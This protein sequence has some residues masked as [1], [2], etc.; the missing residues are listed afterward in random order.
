MKPIVLNQSSLKEYLSCN[1]LYGWR[2]I[3]GLDV[4]VRPAAPSIGIAVHAGLAM[5]H[6]L[7]GA[8]EQAEVKARVTTKE[9]LKKQAGPT[10]AFEDKTLPEAMAIAEGL[11]AAYIDHWRGEE[12]LWSPLNQ[13]IEFKVEVGTNT[14]VFL[15]GRADNLSMVKG[16]LY[17]VDYK[18]AGKMDPRDL[19]KYDLDLQ[20][21]CYTYGLSKLLTNE[22]VA[23]GGSPIRVQ[24]AIIDLLVKTQTPQFARETYTRTD[25]ELEEFEAEFVEYGN[26]IRAQRERVAAGEDWKI[27]FPKNTE[28][29]FKWGRACSFRE[30]CLKDT[31]ER[32]KMFYAPRRPDYVD[33]YEADLTLPPC[34]V[35]GGLPSVHDRQTDPW[36]CPKKAEEKE[37]PSG[38]P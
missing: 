19:L 23:T 11:V 32:R 34:S 8:D 5:F 9:E 20:L 2:R 35:C 21:T 27:V 30:L 13:E 24:G 1:R 4:P 15:I 28:S 31:P 36:T 17:L 29:C 26:R 14:G 16:A 25:A 10:T 18:T 22:S 6:A 37:K 7:Q 33:G 38:N 3:I 12:N